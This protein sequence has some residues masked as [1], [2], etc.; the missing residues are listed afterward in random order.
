M[1]AWTQ[2]RR[3]SRCQANSPG[4]MQEC[5]KFIEWS[6]K[7]LSATLRI[8]ACTCS[9]SC[10]DGRCLNICRS[11]ENSC[12]LLLQLLHENLALAVDV[13][14]EHHN[15]SPILVILGG[16]LSFIRSDFLP[17]HHQNQFAWKWRTTWNNKYNHLKRNQKEGS[18][19]ALF[20]LL[21]SLFGCLRLCKW[22]NRRLAKRQ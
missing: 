4:S 19:A 13:V 9:C 2:T 20:G 16:F 6:K 17:V 15:T 11:P 7:L 18:Y 1:E 12:I 21:I 8:G 22:R 10:C 3:S 14:R 5:N